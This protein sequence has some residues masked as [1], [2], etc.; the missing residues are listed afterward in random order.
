MM[1]AFLI[2]DVR[3]AVLIAVFYMFYR[4]LLRRETF[5][6]VN[7]IVLLGT[8][9]L[10]FVLP[11][12]IITWHRTEILPKVAVTTTVAQAPVATVL[13]VAEPSGQD[14]L[15]QVAMLLF[16]VGA[17]LMLLR[18]LL[19][20]YRVVR[21]VR[22]GEK[23]RG[24]EGTVI[25]V[26]QKAVAPSSWMHYII[27]NQQD[28]HLAESAIIAHEVGHIKARHSL[29]LL[30]VDLLSV[31]QWFNPA[32]WMLRSDLCD[33]HEY[34]ADQAALSHGINAHQY[35]YLLVK[36]AVGETGYSLANSFNQ[37]TLKKRITMMQNINKRHSHWLRLFYVV[38][39]VALSLAAS[40]RTQVDYVESGQ[41]GAA[42]PAASSAH[43]VSAT[44]A[45]KASAVPSATSS[46]DTTL[47]KV[48]SITQGEMDGKSSMADVLR[49]QHVSFEGNAGSASL[50]VIDG[51]FAS[52][53]D[54][55][56]LEA[57]QVES[58]AYLKSKSAMAV[59]GEKGKNGAILVTTKSNSSSADAASKTLPSAA[60]PIG[61]KE[62]RYLQSH[63]RYPVSAISSGVQGCWNAIFTVDKAGNV[64]DVHISEASNTGQD[65]TVFGYAVNDPKT[66]EKSKEE[67]RKEL[68]EEL[69][70]CVSSLPQMTPV[71]RNGKPIESLVSINFN[72]KL[73]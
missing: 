38:P 40:A 2:Y 34:E 12:C 64:K 62:C 6:R 37:S 59:Y 39:I 26:T 53:D 55:E 35:Q 13:P 68:K 33:I 60:S 48:M 56:K 63:L 19:S 71:T 61:E 5:H 17:A 25:V 50:V 18:T 43:A 7:R 69:L 3:V 42:A 31:F 72:Y 58:I 11:F 41:P 28:Y 51:L 9:V 57:N 44:S 1:T 8:A 36:K 30:L 45:V 21:M 29:D 46:S 4:L 14:L 10:S 49:A 27:L 16:L 15:L 32:L 73:K 52:V 67:G 22:C 23:H 54:L 24:P 65:V 70:K 66:D 20:L 47:H